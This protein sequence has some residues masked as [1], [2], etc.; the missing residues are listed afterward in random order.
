MP[1]FPPKYS[2]P[3]Q[4]QGVYQQGGYQPPFFADVQEQAFMPAPRPAK[5]P[6][7]GL[8][9]ELLGLVGFA[10]IGWLWA[11]RTG[12]GLLILFGFWGFLV[13]EFMLLFVLVGFC[14]IPFNFVIPVA[15]A[16]LI[17]KYLRELPREYP[18]THTQPPF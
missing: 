16:L 11:G 14:L 9:L 10:G 13:V 1:E 3:S 18:S 5:E 15:S 17:Q 12:L 2:S 8:L 4:Q 7:T 6:A